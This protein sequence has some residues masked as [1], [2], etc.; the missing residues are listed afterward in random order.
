[1]DNENNPLF[2]LWANGAIVTFLFSMADHQNDLSWWKSLIA[3]FLWPAALI[4]KY[5][6]LY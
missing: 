1:M 6:E 4:A 3:S 2:G 5:L